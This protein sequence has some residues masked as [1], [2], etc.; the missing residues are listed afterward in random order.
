MSS[1]TDHGVAPHGG[2][3]HEERD[4]SVGVVVKWAIGVFV[5]LALSMVAVWPLMKF[6]EH[7]EARESAPASPLASEYG[8]VQPPEPRLQVD[9]AADI[10]KLRAQEQAVLDGYAWVDRPQGTVRIPIDRAI[11]LFAERRGGTK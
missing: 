7:R 10:E 6:Y 5:L 11:T 3:G 9:P 4:V 8:P 1:T 2:A